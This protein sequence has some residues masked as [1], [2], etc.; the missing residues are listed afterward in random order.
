MSDTHMTTWVPS[1]RKHMHS[2][3]NIEYIYIYR[4]DSLHGHQGVHCWISTSQV[5]SVCQVNIVAVIANGL[6]TKLITKAQNTKPN[7]CGKHNF[8]TFKQRTRML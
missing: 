5:S 7:F 1:S 3:R 4:A 2:S 8:I 6:H